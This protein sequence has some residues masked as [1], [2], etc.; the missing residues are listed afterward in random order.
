MAEISGKATGKSAPNTKA[1]K[2]DG[3]FSDLLKPRPERLT[4]NIC[5]FA[6][7]RNTTEVHREEAFKTGWFLGHYGYN[8]VYGGIGS[9]LMWL[10]AEGARYKGARITGVLPGVGIDVAAV[11]VDRLKALGIEHDEGE[12]LLR[13]R[14]LEDRKKRMIHMSDAVISLA[15][16]IG[17]LDELATTLEI[18]R[19]VAARGAASRL[20]LMNT[21]GYYEGLRR[22]LNTMYE[23]GAVDV[24]ADQ[25]AYFAE[26]TEDAFQY[27]NSEIA[28]IKGDV[29][30]K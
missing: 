19:G 30:R 8:M 9:G 5:I 2:R 28:R 16:G 26:N 10:A 25:F 14:S 11:K 22:Q 15:G 6:S 7:A 20:V 27:L 13:T 18:S 3:K 23:A 4:G 24:P 21:D 12:K 29:P 17:T 1:T